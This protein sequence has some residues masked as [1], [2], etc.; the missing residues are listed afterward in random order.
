MG[1]VPW[2]RMGPEELGV[3]LPPLRRDRKKTWSQMSLSM[4]VGDEGE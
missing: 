4:V 1:G 3:A 2:R